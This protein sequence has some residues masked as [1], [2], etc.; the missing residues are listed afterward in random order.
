MVAI[1][2][3]S[4]CMSTTVRCTRATPVV[5]SSRTVPPF[6]SKRQEGC[7]FP[8]CNH[9]RYVDG[10]HIR[11]WAD[12]GETKLSNL[13]T[14]CRFHHRAV[15]EGGL[16]VSRCD[17][18]AWRFTNKHG[19]SLFTCA[20]GH[21]HPLADWTFVPTDNEQRGIVINP[22]TAATRWQ[23]ERMDY[24]V[25]IDSLLFRTKSPPAELGR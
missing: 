6:R 19:Q 1:V 24:G 2:S 25:A 13:V 20:P 3:K 10:H 15:H 22:H 18:G 7:V 21:T 16:K 9:K 8:G 11:H 17:D 12:G 14:L 4:S 23:G 5:A